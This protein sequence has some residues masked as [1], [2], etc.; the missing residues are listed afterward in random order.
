[1]CVQVIE[2]T[3]DTDVC[4]GDRGDD[5]T[6]GSQASAMSKLPK[7]SSSSSRL[8]SASSKSSAAAA[9]AGDAPLSCLIFYVVCH[10]LW[11]K[12]IVDLYNT[13]L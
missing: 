12:V 8:S 4:P 10:T 7:R 11:S 1:M 9:A 13:L 2:V 5:D 3:L 6:D